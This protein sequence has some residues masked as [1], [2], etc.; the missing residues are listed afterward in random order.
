MVRKKKREQKL[1]IFQWLCNESKEVRPFNDL[2]REPKK[3]PSLEMLETVTV[4]D[5][6]S[7]RVLITTS[8]KFLDFWFF[9]CL[10]LIFFF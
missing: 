3:L 6:N 10:N 2:E 8:L 5:Q 9:F 7:K 4:G 1:S